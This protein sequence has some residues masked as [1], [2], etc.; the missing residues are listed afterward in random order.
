M[1]CLPVASVGSKRVVKVALARPLSASWCQMRHQNGKDFSSAP[2]RQSK[3]QLR[4]ST[5]Q[6]LPR[7]FLRDSDPE[8]FDSSTQQRKDALFDIN[9][10]KPILDTRMSKDKY[11]ARNYRIDGTDYLVE[12][13]DGV[14][15]RYSSS[16]IERTIAN[17]KSTAI[18]HE[19]K[20]LWTHL[21][22]D[23]VRNSNSMSMSF[24]VILSEEGMSAGLNAI[25]EFGILLVT[26]TPIGYGG[27]GVAAL[28]SALSG[29]SK[30]SLPSTSLLAQYKAGGNEIVLPHGTEGPL[31]TLY[32]SVWFTSSSS[33]VKG[34]SIADSAYGK[35]ALPLHT[36]M[37]YHRDPPGLQ[38]FTMVQPALKGG[39]SVY[40]DGFAAAKQLFEQDPEAFETL[41]NVIRTYHCGDRE[42]GWELQGQGPVIQMKNGVISSIRHNDIDR[43]PDLAPPSASE[44]FYEK[45]S[46]AHQKWDQILSQNEI[47]LV[48]K[49]QPGDTI[50]VAN[51]RCLHGRHSFQ[52]DENTHRS[53]MGCYVSQDELNSRF[54][55][56]GLECN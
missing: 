16:W 27:V 28:A 4:T 40:G 44:E 9:E 18:V 51:Q 46:L 8:N 24:D 53:V 19:A 13:G 23:D 33:Q 47:R 17:W 56:E 54:R 39:E 42:M 48:M 3:V 1:F 43:L 37:T 31:R 35:E 21:S 15:S 32:G 34:T 2:N 5:I 55:M 36:D 22:E 52:T 25:Y 14:T 26:G 7:H 49:L 20:T 30:K 6:S 12:W 50:V 45:L 41:T 38:I 11:L 29:G 10:G